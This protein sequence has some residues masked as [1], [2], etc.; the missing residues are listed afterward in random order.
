MLSFLLAGKYVA[1]NSRTHTEEENAD[2]C[3]YCFF[4]II[5]TKLIAFAS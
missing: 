5:N 2:G 4:N 3:L 1:C